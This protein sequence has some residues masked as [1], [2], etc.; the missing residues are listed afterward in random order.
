MLPIDTIMQIIWKHPIAT[1]SLFLYTLFCMGFL[2]M[3]LQFH[4]RMKM[5]PGV[6]GIELGG[7][8]VGFG[9]IFLV[10]IGFIFGLITAG[11]AIGSKTEMNY[12]LWLILIIIIETIAV[13]NVAV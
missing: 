7:E 6:S 8:G 5:N 2:R 4:E 9:A 1:I 11:F 13:L 12:Y 3:V 10:I